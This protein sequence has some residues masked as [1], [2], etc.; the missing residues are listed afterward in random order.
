MADLERLLAEVRDETRMLRRELRGLRAGELVAR[1]TEAERQAIANHVL[2]RLDER[3]AHERQAAAEQA[4][5]R[6]AAKGRGTCRYFDRG[7]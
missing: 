6:N 5:S 2:D 7:G 1:L 3:F 4:P